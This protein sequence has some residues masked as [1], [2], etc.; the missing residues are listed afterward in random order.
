MEALVHYDHC[1]LRAISL[2]H[3]DLQ[4]AVLQHSTGVGSGEAALG[5]DRLA[6]RHK[7]AAVGIEKE[8]MVGQRSWRDSCWKAWG[9]AHVHEDDH[10]LGPIEAEGDKQ[11]DA[12]HRTEEDCDEKG[13]AGAGCRIRNEPGA[14]RGSLRVHRYN[15]HRVLERDALLDP[16]RSGDRMELEDRS[17]Q[18]RQTKPEVVEA[19]DRNRSPT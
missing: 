1:S 11:E 14:S 19:G 17:L 7:G 3:S 16:D 10:A 8:G 5:R 6:V 15:G 4:A 2:R 12:R 9:L 18:D 13:M